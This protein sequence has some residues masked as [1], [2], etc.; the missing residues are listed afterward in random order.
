MPEPTTPAAG[1]ARGDAALVRALGTWALAAGIVNVTIGGG[2]FR[3]PAGAARALGTAAPLAWLACAVVMALIVVCFAEAGSRVAT[4]GG[5]Y[6]YVEVAFGPLAGFLV[7]FLLWASMTAALAAVATFFA[8]SVGALVPP[9]GT[10]VPRAATLLAVLA[11]LA[12][13]NVRGVRGAS[14]FNS[15]MT[16]AK[17]TPLALF[18]LVGAFAVRGENLSVGALPPAGDFA[19]ASALLIFAFLGVEAALVPSGEVKDP[20]RTVPRAVFIALGAVAVVYVAVHVVSQGILGPALGAA[21]TPVAD[22]AGA[23]VGGWGRT[24]I[25]VGSVVSMFGYVS[26]MTLAVP[27]ALLA[28]ARDGFLPA[29][30]AAVPPR[31]RTPHVA[32]VAQAAITAVLALSGA[33]EPLA[34]LANGAGLLAYAACCAAAWQ[35]RR[36][37]VRQAGGEPYRSR[38]GAVAP[39]LSLVA[40]AAL[41]TGLGPADWLAVGAAVV[42]AVLIAAVTHGRRTAARPAAEPG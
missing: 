12:L 19:R 8:D 22:A 23:A 20:S 39:A 33:F 18:V 9:L 41:L 13:L 35:L 37:D 25:L 42:A 7:G 36:R 30:L 2:I 17:L 15:V 10:P 29:R 1:P 5:P 38:F 27:R 21:T 14:R 26:G 3:L 16:V 6:A 32:I 40:I 24:L 31:Y 4:T 28:F 34:L 11:A